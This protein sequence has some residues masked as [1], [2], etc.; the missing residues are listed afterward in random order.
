MRQLV[1]SWVEAEKT[2]YGNTLGDAIKAL[3]KECG[4]TLTHPRVHDAP[5]QAAALMSDLHYRSTSFRKSKI[6]MP[7]R[8]HRRLLVL[9]DG[10]RS[11]RR[12]GQ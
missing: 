3:S 2:G 7:R 11:A 5:D 4:I 8:S 10:T 9:I 1:E 6:R 12:E